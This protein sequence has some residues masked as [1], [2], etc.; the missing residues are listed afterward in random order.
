[1]SHKELFESI[2]S[3]AVIEH[4]VDP[5][6]YL[7]TLSSYMGQPETS[8]TPQII[9]TTPH[10][11]MDMIHTFGAAVGLFSKHANE[12]HEELLNLARLE[13]LGLR[14]ALRIFKYRRFCFG[15]N[16]LI[17]LRKE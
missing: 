11:T 14:V 5:L 6:D 1:M 10:P 8:L 7:Q 12:E 4:M 13:K 16:Q 3:M 17:I 15:A 2:V 9:L